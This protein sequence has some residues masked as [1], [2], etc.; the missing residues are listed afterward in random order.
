MKIGSELS[1]IEHRALIDV[2]RKGDPEKTRAAAVAHIRSTRD[3]RIV[4]GMMHPET[5]RAAG[6]WT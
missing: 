1:Y 6:R 3:N 4:P 2:L 5:G